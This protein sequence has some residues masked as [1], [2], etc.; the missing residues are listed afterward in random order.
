MEFNLSVNG[1]SGCDDWDRAA[2]ILEKKARSPT[3]SSVLVNNVCSLLFALL[4][5]SGGDAWLRDRS[6][7]PNS[8]S[9]HLRVAF[10][11]GPSKRRALHIMSLNHHDNTLGWVLLLLPFH[12]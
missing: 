12:R 1:V 9:P 7:T 10:G 11:E 8:S 3:Q 6:S 5:S 4:S 2:I